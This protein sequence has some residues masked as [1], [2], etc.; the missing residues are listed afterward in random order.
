MRHRAAHLSPAKRTLKAENEA[1]R[2]VWR[3][4]SRVAEIELSD[5]SP[6]N[7][8]ALVAQETLV[9]QEPPLP[10]TLPDQPPAPSTPC[11]ADAASDLRQRFVEVFWSTPAHPPADLLSLTVF[12]NA[13]ERLVAAARTYAAAVRTD[14]AARLADADALRGAGPP[15]P[16]TPSPETQP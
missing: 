10:T 15:T 8:E 6:R 7:R 11:V 12:D 1:R 14:H 3:W 13:V 2:A 16:L 4:L 5:L 9:F